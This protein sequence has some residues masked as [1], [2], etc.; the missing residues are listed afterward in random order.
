MSKSKFDNLFV[1]TPVNVIHN[2]ELMRSWV[3]Y[4]RR[5]N[6]E[7]GIAE[8]G[9]ESVIGSHLHLYELERL[10]PTEFTS[11]MTPRLPAE[12]DRLRSMPWSD[13]GNKNDKEKQ[14]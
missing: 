12:I 4:I 5:I 8:V 9:P 6:R 13:T 1:G 11:R 10:V 7:A 2:G 3:G 14:T